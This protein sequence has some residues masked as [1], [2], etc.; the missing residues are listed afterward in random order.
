MLNWVQNPLYSTWGLQ[1]L[2]QDPT[3]PHCTPGFLFSDV[4]ASWDMLCCFIHL[5]PTAFPGLALSIFL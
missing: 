5:F 2:G 1:E 3:V 4:L